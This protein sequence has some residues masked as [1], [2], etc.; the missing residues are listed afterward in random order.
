MRCS[1]IKFIFEIFS[2]YFQYQSQPA[3]AAVVIA[4]AVDVAAFHGDVITFARCYSADFLYSAH[5][6][7]DSKKKHFQ[8]YVII[9]LLRRNEHFYG[10]KRYHVT[11]ISRKLN[12]EKKDLSFLSFYIIRTKNQAL[13]VGVLTVWIYNCYNG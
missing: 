11:F 12:E 10:L 3:A 1:F 13:G 7:V 4:V 2:V 9:K 6:F 8:K 5:H